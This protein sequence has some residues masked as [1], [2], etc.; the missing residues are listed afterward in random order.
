MKLVECVPNFSEGRDKNVI[1]AIIAQIQS[2]EGI[3]LLDVDMGASTNRTVVT[4]VGP[5]EA[6]EEAAFR[7]IK[8][9]SELI[10]MRNHKGAHP[11]LGATDVVPFVPV[12]GVSMD[13]CVEIA[14]RVGKR[15]GEELGIPVFLY[16]YAATA[17]YRRS[18]AAIREGEYE[19]LPERLKDPK[20]QPDFGPAEFNAKA[21]ATVIGAREFLIAYNVT[22]NT[23]RVPIARAIAER[24]REKGGYKR[25]PDL[26]RMKD[27]NGNYIT[28]EGKFKH[29][30]A[31]GW[32]VEE[33]GAAQI[34]INFVNYKE[35][36]IH[37]VVEEIRRLAPEYGVVVTGSELVGLIPKEALLMA[38]RYYLDRQ[39]ASYGVPEDDLIDVA[40]RSL[41]LNDLY[42]FKKEEK[43]IEYRVLG[44]GGELTN[45]KAW[46]F[47]D[48]VSRDS[49]VPGGGSVAALM[50]ALGAA[51]VSMVGN[52][53]VKKTKF[54]AVH[55]QMKE[56]AAKAQKIKD[57]LINA[58]DEDSAS[59]AKVMAAFK[60]PKK[61]PEEKE[62]RA[63]A[64]EDATFEAGLVPF[65]VLKRLPEV[66]DLAAVVARDGNPASVSDAGV[67]AA[68]TIAAARGAYLNVLINMQGLDRDEA[69]ETVNQAKAILDEVIKKGNEVLDL[70]QNKIVE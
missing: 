45:M 30:R 63:K 37:E 5:P 39:G 6:V 53:T 28:I 24:I 25:G 38:G 69:K 11:R 65:G 19:A 2:V 36:P 8:K 35:T 9:A 66:L 55:P 60:L 68:A 7:G 10:D 31:I 32:Y 26:K 67:A 43:V 41:G 21:G 46:E 29:V 64:I 54:M 62:V 58:V 59:Y 52:L 15:V 27:E 3:S 20:W 49:A 40:V 33:Y 42:P 18:L 48:E 4:F 23:K 13:D 70:V 14:K 12:S 47:A 1:D 50:G 34:S 61:T 44:K 16:E 22:L 17:D 57:F 51:L 56:V